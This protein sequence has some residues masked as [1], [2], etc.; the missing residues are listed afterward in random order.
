MLF[1]PE[2]QE[3]FSTVIIYLDYLIIDRMRLIM[4]A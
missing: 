3:S 4:A 2:R 1:F